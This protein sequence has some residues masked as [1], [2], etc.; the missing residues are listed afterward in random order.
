MKDLQ[1]I[2]QIIEKTPNQ[3]S[4]KQKTMLLDKELKDIEDDVKQKSPNAAFQDGEI[5][6]AVVDDELR[7]EYRKKWIQ[8]QQR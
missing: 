4:H 3:L 6:N 2:L 5:C 1:H 7:E 8:R